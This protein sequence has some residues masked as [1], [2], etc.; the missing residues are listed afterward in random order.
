MTANGLDCVLGSST[1]DGDVALAPDVVDRH[2]GDDPLLSGPSGGDVVSVLHQ[3]V[4]ILDAFGEV[5]RFNERVHRCGV[6]SVFDSNIRNGVARIETAGKTT[7]AL[8][9]G[10]VTLKERERDPKFV[11]SGA[12][13]SNAVCCE[14]AADE[15]E[16]V[17]I[18]AVCETQQ[19]VGDR[20]LIGKKLKR[21]HDY[22]VC[23]PVAPVPCIQYLGLHRLA[24]KTSCD[25]KYV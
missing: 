7:E 20:Y 25:S 24:S 14:C 5:L 10:V 1:D 6:S 9:D 19:G 4:A 12:E 11:G 15:L 21:V 13:I 3:D 17:G 18:H 8:R 23:L 2:A 16:I 22:L